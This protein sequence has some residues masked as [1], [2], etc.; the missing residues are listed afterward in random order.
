[1]LWIVN[2]VDVFTISP[3]VDD[4]QPSMGSLRG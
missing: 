4:V 2:Q 3:D 1:M